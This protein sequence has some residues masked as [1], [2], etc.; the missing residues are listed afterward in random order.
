MIAAESLD[1]D[2]RALAEQPRGGRYRVR[3]ARRRGDRAAIGLDQPNG[4]PA[5][6]TR[7]RLSVKSAIAGIVVLGAAGRAHR[8]LAHRRPRAV[9]R[10]ALDDREPRPAVGAVDERVPVAA[11]AGV[12]Q[13]RQAVVAGRAVGG[14]QRVGL[15]PGRRFY[16]PKTAL[17]R[18]R[19]RRGFDRSHVGK[20]RGLGA[21]AGEEAPDA[22][23][24]TLDLE[25]DAALVVQ[26]PAREIELLGEPEDER[27]EADALHRAGDPHG[28]PPSGAK[29]GRHR[30]S[31]GRRLNSLSTK[32]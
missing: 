23:G 12:E 13:L 3:L 28:D 14:D 20:R 17:T 11:V 22:I 27:P 25:L 7:V 8:E 19:D 5:G 6:G 30:H 4:G 24:V 29:R 18:N 10:H 15:A 32:P 31:C 16:D 9:I 1:G 26:H 2:D 21:Q